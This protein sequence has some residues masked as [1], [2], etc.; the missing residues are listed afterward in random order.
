MS[1]A[2][3]TWKA[4]DVIGQVAMVVLPL[5]YYMLHTYYPRAIFA[6]LF[7]LGSWQTLSFLIH[8]AVM[9]A[10]WITPGRRFYLALYILVVCCGLLALASDGFAGIYFY[11]MLVA[12]PIMGIIY[13]DVSITEWQKLR[14]MHKVNN[15]S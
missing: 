9:R 3:R 6:I 8:L 2:V 11:G 13:F 1:N 5:L 15:L 10:P 14:S 7:T 4:I 12:G